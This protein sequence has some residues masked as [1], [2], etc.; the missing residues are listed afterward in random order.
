M[1]Q[2]SS[3]EELGSLVFELGRRQHRESFAVVHDVAQ[4]RGRE[5]G[6]QRDGDGMVGEDGK[7]SDCRV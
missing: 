3:A 4:L 1:F 5:L 2:L 7:Q 6:R